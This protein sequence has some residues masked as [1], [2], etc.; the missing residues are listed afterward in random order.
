M[1]HF[2]DHCLY[3]LLIRHKSG[4]LSNLEI[5]VIISNHPDLKPVADMFGVEFRCLPIQE[6]GIS[7]RDGYWVIPI[8]YD[9]GFVSAG[10]IQQ[11]EGNLGRVSSLSP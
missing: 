4:E 9:A 2:Q 6:K 11:I 8:G 3:D 1:Y 5:P 10:V 7:E